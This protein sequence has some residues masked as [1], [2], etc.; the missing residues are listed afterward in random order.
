MALA[1][2]TN[3]QV[4]GD[5]RSHGSGDWNAPY[6]WEQWTGSAWIADY[7]EYSPGSV[8]VPSDGFPIISNTSTSAKTTTTN[9]AHTISLPSG[10]QSGDLLVIFWA[11][12]DNSSTEPSLAGWTELASSNSST[13]GVYR[14]IW[15]RIAD[16][17]EGSSVSTN[18]FGDRSAHVVYRI[19]AGSYSGTPFVSAAGN[20]TDNS[21]NAPNLAP[22]VGSQKFLWLASV[23]AAEV[24]TVTTPTNF[25]SDLGIGSTGSS[26]NRIH[27]QVMTAQRNLEAAS[28]DVGAFSL[29]G[30]AT[31]TAW[32]VAIQGME[33]PL[34]YPH[35]VVV[36]NSTGVQSG[37]DVSSHNINL[38]DGA[39][40]DLLV[41]IFSVDQDPTV[42]TS[43]SGWTKLGQA[44]NGSTVTGAIFWKTASG[45]SSV[46]DALILTTSSNQRSSHVTYRIRGATG[47]SGAAANGSSTNSNPPSH[48][49]SEASFL[50]IA[51]R[52]GDAQVVASSAP[53]NYS[54]LFSVDGG[55]TNGAS[56]NSAIR[57]LGSASATQDPG[58]FTSGN[59]Q[60]VSYTL[61]I[62]GPAPVATYIPIDLP[63]QAS[64]NGYPSV[65][66]TATSA[67]T[68]ATGTNHTASLPS[69]IQNG[70]L[71]LLFWVDAGTSSTLTT[72]S[73]WTSL[74][75]M[76]GTANQRR[77]AF[78]R[79]ADGSE[80]A[81]LDL[82]TSAAERS[83]HTVYRIA[84]GSF[85]GVPVPGSTVSADSNTADPPTL[86]SGFGN[87]PTLWFAAIHAEGTATVP[88]PANYTDQLDVNS[89]GTGTAHAR[90][91]S[92]IRE[93]QATSEDPGS[94]SF[95]TVRVW[96]A[97]TIAIRG[98]ARSIATVRSGHTVT[99]AGDR[100]IDD[101][102]V[103]NGAT[104]SINSGSLVVN[105]TSMVVNGNVEGEGTLVLGNTSEKSIAVTGSGTLQPFNLTANARNGVNMGVPTTIRGTLQLNE[106][107]F[108]AASAVSLVSNASGT[109]RLG[110][111]DPLASYVGNLTVNRFIPA[112]ATNWRMI[113]SSVAGQTVNNLKDDF[114]TA[115]FPGSH[116]PTFSNPVGS[117]I[118]W[119]SIR[120]YDETNTGASM[121][122]GL[123][124]VSGT[125]QALSPGQ[126]FA[127]WCGTGLPTTTAFN[128]DVTGQ[129]HIAHA[130]MALPMS[131]TNTGSPVADG[132]NMVSNPL[133]SPIAFDQISRGADVADYI[134]YFNPTNGNLATWDISEGFGLNGGTNVIQSSQ[135]F[136][137][138]A[139]G[140]AV[141]TTVSESAKV[142]GNTGGHFGGAQVQTANL[143]R[144]RIQSTINQF[145][146]ETILV[147][148]NGILAQDSYDVPKFVFAHPDAPQIAAISEEGNMLA[149]NAHGPYTSDIS[150]PI[151]VDV[152][153]NGQY[154][155]VAEGLH[156]IGL[157][158]VRF[159]DL[160]TG[161]ITPLVEGASYTFTALAS[162]DES[163]ARFLL[164]ASAPVQMVATDAT[165]N[166]RDDGSASLAITNG[167]VD[168][169]WSDADG[170][171][172]LEQNNVMPGSN[173]LQAL[174]AGVYTVRLEG[175][176]ACGS[177]STTFTIEE[178]SAL[179]AE[180]STMPSTCPDSD[181]GTIDLLVLGGQAPYTY[182][183]SN[184]A[185]SDHLE[186]AAGTYTVLITDAN[187]CTLA[188]Q[189]YVVGAGEGPDAGIN[190]A[191]TLV[192]VGAEVFFAPNNLEGVINT[193]EFGD[194]TISNSL[195]AAHSY[196][197]PGTYTVT[198]TVD[199]G[200]CIS[201]ATLDMQVETSTGI[202]TIV[203]PS[204]NVWAS[205]DRIIIDHDLE[206]DRPVLISIHATNG[207]VLQEYHMPGTSKHIVL[208][209]SVVASGVYLVRV[210]NG[211][212]MRTFALARTN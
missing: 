2:A 169:I 141:N 68:S 182:Q 122:D 183:W 107:V 175:A 201:T 133:P 131:Y 210:S 76:V 147:F 4:V 65:A 203:G 54:D 136:W 38:P 23:H 33:V 19:A 44:S 166:G 70:D 93:L 7:P 39:V 113:G 24:Q 116:S 174:Y 207:Q 194:G 12:A 47:I 196:S 195:E 162:D 86:T 209:N 111:V 84:A 188:P 71:L 108:T 153:I 90:M 48:T 110:P 83:A 178:P 128:I 26:T 22:G 6:T 85:Q 156:N 208:T 150:I 73:G 173:D 14:K 199:N 159:E 204:F 98:V 130:P 53:S 36:G 145:S 106:G 103:E 112:G 18:S 186:V 180:A 129:P 102:V 192:Q 185:T 151:T 99:V 3:A 55:N 51:T 63:V 95:G 190:V 16:G 115:G 21:P 27:C 101:L 5:Y 43:S 125:S 13:S 91:A 81:M 117:G 118:L 45:A 200:D 157:S 198:L 77:A 137:L 80:G 211:I 11:D 15:Y 170:A 109:G 146:D 52:A 158:C 59:E 28:Q 69:G 197:Q 61:A 20:D 181:D 165:C 168:V 56:T 30:S 124:G 172:L 140:P 154:T 105:G 96:G 152:A 17:N 179:E 60:W 127:A 41:A 149:I 67:K 89:G 187:G 205:G 135:A 94:V 161:T 139:N 155:I 193:W 100:N 34:T 120:W 31:H 8:T 163:E 144:L 29:G 119:P 10:I 74:Y 121:N 75:N 202:P 32:T 191:Q 82:T 79:I 134:T 212:Q 167:P 171:V 40:G 148:N 62:Q 50:W 57:T 206:D 189:E 64:G 176:S 58:S 97:N 142:S 87:V 9:A 72:P 25:G 160:A 123:V 88:T 42:S 66:N 46:D 164:H 104:V 138:K 143:V 35:P 132:W 114:T 1:L 184:E 49:A 126:G 177:L 92:S 37:A 78:Y